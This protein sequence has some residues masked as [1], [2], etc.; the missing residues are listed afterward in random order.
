M[1]AWIIS[2]LV[3]LL[4]TA[5]LFFLISKLPLGVEVDSFDK[6]IIAAIVFAV[7]NALMMPIRGVLNFG[8]LEFL[9]FPI[10]WLL[11]VAVFGLTA[12]L[13]EGFRL[14][15]IWSAIFGA[16]AFAVANQIVSHFLPVVNT[17]KP[18]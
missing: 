17:V 5:A 15:S 14:R 4:V 1:P 16:F 8:P 3:S 6:A 11:N 12:K 2:A 7:L 13:V 10:L 9:F 18:I